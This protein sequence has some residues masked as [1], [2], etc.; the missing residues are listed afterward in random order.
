MFK[1]LRKKLSDRK[2][3]KSSVYSE[4]DAFTYYDDGQVPVFL[5]KNDKGEICT[6]FFPKTEDSFKNAFNRLKN[7]YLKRVSYFT[8]QENVKKYCDYYNFRDE[9]YDYCMEVYKERNDLLYA[10]KNI[11][12]KQQKSIG[13]NR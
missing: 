13:L 9:V 12:S 3:E 10:D 6:L 4:F 11:N 8:L 2:T 5:A 7:I 1:I